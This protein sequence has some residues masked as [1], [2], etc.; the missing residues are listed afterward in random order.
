MFV[1]LVLAVTTHL[2]FNLAAWRLTTLRAKEEKE[3]K[4]FILYPE[5][6]GLEAVQGQE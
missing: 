4:M 1:F 5:P 2:I 6:G 3:R